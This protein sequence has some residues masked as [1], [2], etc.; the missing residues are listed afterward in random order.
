[1][2]CCPCWNCLNFLHVLVGYQANFPFYKIFKETSIK[3]SLIRVTF[4]KLPVR[5][6]LKLAAFLISAILILKAAETF[7]TFTANL[8]QIKFSHIISFKVA[9]YSA[10]CLT[11][12]DYIRYLL[13]KLTR[14]K[15][16]IAAMKKW[17][18]FLF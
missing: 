12:G 9:S 14:E 10:C 18:C 11:S 6:I 8:M 7:I 2:T 3:T 4:V 5:C 15:E 16:V 1:M 17:K 13:E